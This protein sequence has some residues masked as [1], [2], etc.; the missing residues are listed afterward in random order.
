MPSD[1]DSSGSSK[2]GLQL[3]VDL[4]GSKGLRD[5]SCFGTQSTRS[6]IRGRHAEQTID[7][8]TIVNFTVNGRRITD[9]SDPALEINEYVRNVSFE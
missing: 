3:V 4:L 2:I 5:I 9:G 1:V 8:V 6:W 7:G